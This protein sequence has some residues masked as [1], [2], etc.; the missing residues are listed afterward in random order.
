[1]VAEDDRVSQMIIRKL[2]VHVGA[3]VT[4]VG[5]GNAAI[6]AWCAAPEAYDLLLLDMQMPGLDGPGAARALIE[7]GCRTPMVALTAHAGA[8]AVRRCLD[9]GMVGH[10]SKP[11]RPET[12]STLR[13][14]AEGREPTQE[15]TDAMRDWMALE[16]AT[17][18]AP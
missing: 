3:T 2:L 4:L 9:A 14:F 10:L 11:V 1:M 12:L 18:A 8:S 17:L 13:P 16:A 15:D 5:D 6:A 7:A